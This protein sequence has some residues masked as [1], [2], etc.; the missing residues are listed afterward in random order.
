[1]LLH[2]KNTLS[3]LRHFRFYLIYTHIFPSSTFTLPSSQVV[4]TCYRCGRRLLAYTL[5]FPPFTFPFCL[6]PHPHHLLSCPSAL[7]QVKVISTV[8]GLKHISKSGQVIELNDTAVF[9]TRR[10]QR[11]SSRYVLGQ[12]FAGSSSNPPTSPPPSLPPLPPY[13]SLCTR[14]GAHPTY[15]SLGFWKASAGWSCAGNSVAAAVEEGHTQHRWSPQTCRTALGAEEQWLCKT[16][17]S[18]S[19]LHQ[20]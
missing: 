10:R 7:C 13:F 8:V 11:G 18:A 19:R 6:L 14:P 5:V 16:Y 12:P 20:H 3:L 1:M 2:K 17:K 15:I 9:N 4:R